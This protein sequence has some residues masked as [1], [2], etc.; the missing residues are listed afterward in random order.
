MLQQRPLLLPFLALAVGLTITDQTGYH[1]PLYVVAAALLCLVL[2]ALIRQRAPFTICVHL[3]FFVLGLCALS[4][5]KTPTE[6]SCSLRNISAEVPV[7]LQGVVRSRPVVSPTGTSLVVRTEQLLHAGHSEQVCGDLMLYV[8]EGD[9]SLLRGDRIR[10]A[11]R[12]NMP[13]RLGLPG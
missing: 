6:P 7:T 9:V 11:T 12:V 3:F 2:S 4:P 1:I 8:S 5:W 13:R 10:F